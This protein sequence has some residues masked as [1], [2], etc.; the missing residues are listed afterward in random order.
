MQQLKVRQGGKRGPGAYPLLVLVALL[1]LI[2]VNTLGGFDIF[3][4]QSQ[5]QTEAPRV[6]PHLDVNPYGSNFFLHL[7]VEN[8]KIDKTLQM[9][10][11]AGIG[12]VKQQFPWESIE[13]SAGR[14]WD[15]RYNVST[16]DKFDFIV[17]TAEKYGMQ[18]IA[19]LDRPP[20][21]ARDP[22]SSAMS[23]PKDYAAY[24]RFVYEV[25][26]R[27]KGHIRYY[28]IWNEPNLKEEWGGKPVDP[29]AYVALLKVAYQEI[30]RADPDA[31]VLSAP[32][33]QTL[34]RNQAHLSDV[35]FLEGMYKNGAQG[36]FDVLFANAYGFSLPPDDPPDPGVLNF[37]R[38][39]LLRQI[40]EKN[41]DAAKPVWFNEFGWNAVPPDLPSERVL[42][43]RVTEQQQADYT[44]R[45]ITMAHA[46]WP[47][48]GVFNLW[49]F[50]QS[51]NIP[52]TDAQY[53]FRVVDVGFTPRL[54][55]R[56]VRDV[57]TPLKIAGPG[58]YQETN[59]ALVK[60]QGWRYAVDD[61]AEANGIIVAE[62]VGDKIVISFSGGSLSLLARTGPNGGRLYVSLDG[63]GVESLPNDA[64]GSAYLDL[65]SEQPVRQAT[66]PVVTGLRP[67]N[68]RLELTYA[69]EQPPKSSGRAVAID[70]FTV[71]H[72]NQFP[73]VETTTGL[74]AL[75]A[76][77]G[78]VV[79]RRRRA[80]GAGRHDA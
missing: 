38:V 52:P 25:A 30:K 9:A 18:V 78:V 21:W 3:P 16:W 29:K 74:V 8:W 55:Y 59:P 63:N 56:A 66:I 40:M 42:W 23:P 4:A 28:Q 15:D 54:V 10:S 71:G 65:Y 2:P 27:Y 26:K 75:V 33:A 32:L 7:E 58:T 60:A 53:Y 70:G 49:F 76:V 51:G 36:Y 50:R 22:E 20:D 14:F 73:W 61:Q 39:L 41:G 46:Q 19:R 62:N 6:T 80:Y 57:A 79:W 67:G 24:G 43:G 47:W 68:H 12:W 35:D 11:Q 1:L 5:A 31:F 37:S 45:A 17:A 48:A 13:K 44:V 34:E 69:A 64:G 77:L 72:A